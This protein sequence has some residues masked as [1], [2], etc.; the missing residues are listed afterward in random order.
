MSDLATAMA[1]PT[2]AR[3]ATAR[4]VNYAKE[5]EFSDAEVDLFEDQSEEEAKPTKRGRK[6]SSIGAARP[7]TATVT[8]SS[9][10]EPTAPT[11]VTTTDHSH[12]QHHHHHGT[13][14]HDFYHHADRPV[15]SEKNYDPN[16]PPIRE[17][18]PFLP[19]YEEDG[20]PKIELIVGRR[21]VDEKE[22]GNNNANANDE[23]EDDTDEENG[24]SFRNKRGGGGDGTRTPKSGSKSRSKKRNEKDDDE[25]D[26]ASPS[27]RRGSKDPSSSSS[28]SQHVVEYEYLVKYKG[29][30]YLHLEWKTGADLESMNKSA[31]GIYRRY[32]KKLSTPPAAIGGVDIDE[33]ESPEFDPSYVV[34]EKVLDEADQEIA[35]ELSDAELIAWEEE[36]RQ[37]QPDEDEDDD[38]EEEAP[39]PTKALPATASSAT[40]S[41]G[42]KGTTLCRRHH[43][44]LCASVC[45][46]VVQLIIRLF[47]QVW[48]LPMPRMIGQ[49]EWTTRMFPLSICGTS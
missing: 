41:N 23:E 31:K 48:T 29:R 32:L 38:D 20:S 9:H 47:V 36:Q 1:T 6:S 44:P 33:L 30:S 45:V 19:E 8:A 16:L 2:R 14:D 21:P 40:A 35:I 28:P 49:M 27:R 3:R 46:P 7:K 42:D 34:P 10:H 5:Q 26:H 39:T 24:T 37:S 13:D 17:R 11:T 43:T 12:S 25:D 15:Y 18:F 22:D 4:A